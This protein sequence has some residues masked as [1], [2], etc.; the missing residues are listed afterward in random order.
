MSVC[1]G[2]SANPPVRTEPQQ[3]TFGV[4]QCC[5]NDEVA[6]SSILS[7]IPPGTSVLGVVPG[8]EF[9]TLED[10]LGNFNKHM[11]DA[12]ALL[13]PLIFSSLLPADSEDGEVF[14]L[15]LPHFLKHYY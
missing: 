6:Q 4:F 7:L 1:L 2:K 11:G 9:F 10:C 15:F 5:D 12:G 8:L 14:L 13:L 3:E